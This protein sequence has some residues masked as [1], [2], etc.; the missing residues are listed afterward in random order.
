MSASEELIETMARAYYDWACV[1]D[2]EESRWDEPGSHQAF[3]RTRAGVMLDAAL[4]DPPALLRLLGMEQIG[5]HPWEHIYV[6][7][8]GSGE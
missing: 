3:A 8:S 4:A 6:P 7:I 2:G 1:N 5:V